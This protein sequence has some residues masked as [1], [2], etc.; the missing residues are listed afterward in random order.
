ML[1]SLL[2]HFLERLFREDFL[3]AGQMKQAG[4]LSKI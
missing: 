4:V 1:K 2:A 3:S